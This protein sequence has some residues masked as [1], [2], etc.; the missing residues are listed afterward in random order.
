MLRPDWDLEEQFVVENLQQSMQLDSTD[1]THPMTDLTVATKAQASG[2]FDNIS[3][4]KAGSIIRMLSHY[5]GMEKFGLTL[6]RYLDDNRYRAVE[7]AD[8]FT[9]IE[10]VNPGNSSLTQWFAPWT[11]TPGFPLVTVELNGQTLKLK[12]KRF[13]RSGIN[14][15]SKERYNIPITY[16]I[17]SD[18]YDDTTP[19]FIFRL[20]NGEEMLANLTKVPQKYYIL[21]TKQNGYYRVNYDANNWNKIKEALYKDDHDKI[22]VMNRAQIVDDLFN[23]ARAGI[24]NYETAIDIIRY[25]KKEKHYIPWLSAINHGLTFL[26]QR[27]SGEKNQEVF[28]WFILDTM[29]EIYNH[30]KFIENPSTERRTDIYNRVNV[31]TWACKYGHEDCIKISKEQFGKV[32]AGTKI[33]KDQRSIVY[34]NAVRH[35]GQ[36][37]FDVLY[38]KFKIEDIAAEQLNQLIGM[39]CTKDAALVKVK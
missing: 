11:S 19:K 20:E 39:A 27:V 25:I 18:N 35:G 31:L 5:I 13:K 3:Y 37:E 2:M 23:L 15:D 24:V 29:S 34:C 36:A 38:N 6:K 4:N 9:A 30:L 17:D 21:N 28:S 8:L 1:D 33:P 26:S 12:Q 16:A 14:H 22:H 10:I 7:P 32:K